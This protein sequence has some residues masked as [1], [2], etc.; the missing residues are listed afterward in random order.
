[1]NLRQESYEK[2]LKDGLPYSKNLVLDPKASS[3]RVVVR[4]RNGGNLGT[5]TIPLIGVN[6]DSLVPRS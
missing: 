5:V 1:L 6:Q 2:M 3:L 4:D